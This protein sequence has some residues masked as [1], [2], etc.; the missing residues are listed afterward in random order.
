MKK[1]G[2]K[3][4]IVG[5]AGGM[6]LFLA[7]FLQKDFEVSI[8]D[9]NP[10]GRRISDEIG[11]NFSDEDEI[12]DFDIVIVSVPIEVAPKVIGEVSGRMR[13]NS[14][15]MDTTSIKKGVVEAM[16]KV[17]GK[18]IATIAAHPL[19]APTFPDL[20]GQMV[21]LI[22]VEER[23]W[24]SRVKNFLESKGAHVEISDAEEHDRMMSV[25]QS[26]THFSNIS[27]GATL[28][29]LDFDLKRSKRFTSPIYEVML[30]MV[31]RI[32]AQNP[33]LYASIQ[34]NPYAKVVREKFIETCERLNDALEREETDYFVDEMRKAAKHFGDPER[35]LKISEKLLRG[36]NYELEKIDVGDEV[37]FEHLYSKKIHHGIVDKIS[38]ME[39]VLRKDESKRKIKLKP[40]NIRLLTN[41]ELKRWKME[42]LGGYERD[43]SVHFEN[44]DEIVPDIICEI[45]MGCGAIKA[46]LIDTYREKKSFTFKVHLI[47]EKDSGEIEAKIKKILMGVGGKIR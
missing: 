39:V 26:L 18:S 20:K 37:A 7:K 28:K 25:I 45:M 21:I 32:L 29:E 35:S 36:K 47:E 2:K 27:L 44:F 16:R 1:R 5:G 43:I 12:E 34:K 9:I 22:P 40:E 13:E 11:V 38:P 41:S 10:E 15:L 3:I 14:L 24:L 46:E 33:H 4:L 42:N 19:F 8:Y 6:G 31:G 30:D 17:K 23:G